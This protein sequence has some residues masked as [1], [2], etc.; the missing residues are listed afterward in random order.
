[1]VA[2][3]SFWSYLNLWSEI[4]L[5]VMSAWGEHTRLSCF[6]FENLGNLSCFA[7]LVYQIV[8]GGVGMNTNDGPNRCRN[9]SVS[10]K[11]R[12]HARTGAGG[13]SGDL[14]KAHVVVRRASA[15]DLICKQATSP[16]TYARVCVC[17]FGQVPARLHEGEHK[18]TERERH[19]RVLRRSSLDPFGDVGRPPDGRETE[20]E[21]DFWFPEDAGISHGAP[22]L[23]SVHF[24]MHINKYSW[25]RAGV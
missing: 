17:V 19:R 13:P 12:T 16:L 2:C 21:K 9:E 14:K 1:M 10:L 20:T 23:I 6:L 18:C 25:W 24:L 22:A 7:A 8:K 4:N 3:D 15:P 5:P 11:T